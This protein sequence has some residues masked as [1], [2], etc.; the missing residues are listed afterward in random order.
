MWHRYVV[1]VVVECVCVLKYNTYS[2]VHA[3]FRPLTSLYLS[4][5]ISVYLSLCLFIYIYTN[6][7]FDSHHLLLSAIHCQW[8]CGQLRTC[9]LS[10]RCILDHSKLDHIDAIVLVGMVEIQETKR[11]QIRKR[12]QSKVS[13]LLF[14]FPISASFSFV[15][16]SF[17]V[18]SY[19]I[20]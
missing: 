18:T 5:S 12:I 14:P 7:V 19:L 20:L 2:N 15:N 11:R 6:I 16:Y 13:S 10:T 1:A 9:E 4:V 17:L 8:R 3:L